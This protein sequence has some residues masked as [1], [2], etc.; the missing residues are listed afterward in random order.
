MKILLVG[1]SS[2]WGVLIKLGIILIF[3][4]CLYSLASPSDNHGIS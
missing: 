1:E 2:L 3:F 4:V